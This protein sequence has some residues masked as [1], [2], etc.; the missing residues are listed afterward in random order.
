MGVYFIYQLNFLE[1]I[2]LQRTARS[3]QLV[4]KRYLVEYDVFYG[5]SWLIPFLFLISQSQLFLLFQLGWPCLIQFHFS[6]HCNIFE[7]KNYNVANVMQEEVGYLMQDRIQK[8][9]PSR[10][11]LWNWSAHQGNELSE[12][13]KCKE[14]QESSPNKR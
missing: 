13:N 5:A 14:S 1:Y 8:S 11:L 2:A 10:P 12:G 4:E 6:G 3:D 7:F 9:A